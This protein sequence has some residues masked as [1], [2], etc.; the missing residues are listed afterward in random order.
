MFKLIRIESQS[1]CSPR[2]L[3]RLAD[4]TMKEILY[5]LIHDSFIYKVDGPLRLSSA[6][7]KLMNITGLKSHQRP[8]MFLLVVPQL[9]NPNH[10]F[11]VTDPDS[12]IKFC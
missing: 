9:L 4:R 8:P 12:F 11:I 5:K 2:L 10:I 3:L 6:T 1:S 7:G